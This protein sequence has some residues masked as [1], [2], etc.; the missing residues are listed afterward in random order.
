MLKRKLP[1]WLALVALLVF[2]ASTRAEDSLPE[3]IRRVKPS[4]VSVITYNAAG[5]VSIDYGKSWSNWYNQ[6]TAQ[7]YHVSTDNAF[8]YRVYGAQQDSGTVAVPSR[9][10]FGAISWRD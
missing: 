3:L 1:P 8:P 7:L 5:E 10:D 6:P 9:S 2:A 4:V